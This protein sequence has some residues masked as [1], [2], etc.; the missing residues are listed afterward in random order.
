MTILPT[1]LFLITQVLRDTAVKM[2]GNQVSPPVTAALQGL[3]NIVTLTMTT[4][5]VIHK[6][7]TNLIR[8]TLATILEYSQPGKVNTITGVN[9]K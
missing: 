5:E 8:S 4:S 6:Q 9:F 7:W 2:T 1:I 3:K